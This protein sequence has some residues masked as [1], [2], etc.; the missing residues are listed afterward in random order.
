MEYVNDLKRSPLGELRAVKEQ[1]AFR[2]VCELC[3]SR[4]RGSFPKVYRE[5]AQELENLPLLRHDLEAGAPEELGKIDTFSREDLR[6]LEASL[7]RLAGGDWKLAWDWA[8]ERL[9]S[10]SL[11][12]QSE[13]DRKHHWELVAACAT[14]SRLSQQQ[15]HPLKACSSLEDVVETYSTTLH[16]VDHAHRVVEQLYDKLRFRPE[17]ASFE[18]AVEQVRQCYYAWLDQLNRAFNHL[19][20]QVG[21]LPPAHLQQRQ[22]YEQVVHPLVQQ[23]KK[24]AFF[25]IESGRRSLA[26]T[27]CPFL[28]SSL[29]TSVAAL[30]VPALVGLE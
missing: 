28:R 16:R 5:V 11:W 18:G 21:F 29:I 17:H 8:E 7:S 24:T 22:L 14:L 2:K 1:M 12:L 23:Q 25:L 3:L 27:A 6:L 15:S 30:I 4:V 10:P 13:P 9:N 20:E 26:R 19:C